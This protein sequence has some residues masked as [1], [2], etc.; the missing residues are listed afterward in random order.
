[1]INITQVP[2]EL[3]QAFLN[4]PVLIQNAMFDAFNE[5]RGIFNITGSDGRTPFPVA[6]LLDKLKVSEDK[7]NPD[8]ILQIKIRIPELQ[9]FEIDTELAY[10]DIESYA[11]AWAKN[12]FTSRQIRLRETNDFTFAQA[13]L[14]KIADEGFMNNF[15]T[16][17]AFYGV[18]SSNLALRGGAVVADGLIT[19]IAKA[20]ATNQIPAANIFEITADIVGTEDAEKAYLAVQNV[21]KR[22]SKNPH[23]KGK[24]LICVLS[25]EMLQL[26]SQHR[27]SIN[28]N[29]VES[30]KLAE[31]PDYYPNIKFKT[32]VGMAGGNDIVI[33]H[34]QNLW[35]GLEDDTNNL[36]I[37]IRESVKSTQFNIRTS[38]FVDFAIGEHLYVGLKS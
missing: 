1:M 11:K 34:D 13:M 27:A 5:L 30:G 28:P 17:G 38:V 37:R 18:R 33:T 7:F 24:Q 36:R 35:I 22:A 26:Y 16:K 9:G 32:P 23:L 2:A 15:A 6:T 20:V 31:S 14:M 4:N 3:Q 21:A 12:L 19:K 29:F 8:E 25:E 10:S